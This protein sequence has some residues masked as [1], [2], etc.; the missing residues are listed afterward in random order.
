[1][2]TGVQRLY[3]L[4]LKYDQLAAVISQA[5]NEYVIA[6]FTNREQYKGILANVVQHMGIDAALEILDNVK[7]GEYLIGPNND[8]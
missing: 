3:E 4:I 1:M 7:T 6:T 2:D 8:Q 5:H